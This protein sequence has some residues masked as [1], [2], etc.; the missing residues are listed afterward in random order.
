M[1]MKF[2]FFNKQSSR[3]NIDKIIYKKTIIQNKGWRNIKC[4]RT[5]P[6]HHYT[7]EIHKR[8]VA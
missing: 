5:P 6:S 2:V 3:L 1:Q 4:S 8:D 7:R